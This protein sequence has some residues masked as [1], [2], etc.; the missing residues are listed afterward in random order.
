M[1]KTRKTKSNKSRRSPRKLRVFSPETALES[2]KQ[3]AL[4]YLKTYPSIKLWFAGCPSAEMLVALAKILDQELIL[5]RTR[6]YVTD[7]DVSRL[8][9]T[10]SQLRVLV[11]SSAERRYLERIAFFEHNLATDASPNEFQLIFCRDPFSTDSD[12]RRSKIPL[13]FYESL[14]PFGLLVLPSTE[15]IS[16]DKGFVSVTGSKT[17]YKRCG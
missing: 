5:E 11:Q 4:P 16:D 15:S 1:P 8:D 12:V 14:S 6:I 2:F 9:E 7:V 10:K 13:L 3:L 17:Y